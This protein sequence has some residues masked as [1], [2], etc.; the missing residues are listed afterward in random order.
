MLALRVVVVVVVLDLSLPK[1]KR[2]EGIPV[3]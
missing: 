2:E 3:S 1:T